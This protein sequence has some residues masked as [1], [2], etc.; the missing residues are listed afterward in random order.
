MENGAG[1]VVEGEEFGEGLQFKHVN[2]P[3]SCFFSA[4]ALPLPLVLKSAHPELVEGFLVCELYMTLTKF[5]AHLDPS[6]S[7]G[8]AERVD[9]PKT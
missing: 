8:C 7:S 6:T 2:S 4:K 3:Q 9:T 1:L 5:A